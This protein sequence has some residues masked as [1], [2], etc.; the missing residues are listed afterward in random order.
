MEKDLKDIYNGS[1]EVDSIDLTPGL[2]NIYR[3]YT[4]QIR[5]S[6]KALQSL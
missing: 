1:N 4:E 6:G 3:N 2:W 5:P